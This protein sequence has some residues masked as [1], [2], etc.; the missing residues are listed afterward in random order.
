MDLDGILKEIF[1]DGLLKIPEWCKTENPFYLHSIFYRIGFKDRDKDIE[2]YYAFPGSLSSKIFY[3][4]QGKNEI[5]ETGKKRILSEIKTYYQDFS[6]DYL[7]SLTSN[8]LFFLLEKFGSNI[9]VDDE[10]MISI[11]DRYKIIAARK[12]I[13]T[14]RENLGHSENLFINIDISGIQRFIYN[15]SSA[16][17]L[18]N[19]RSRSF[20][21]ELLCNHIVHKVLNAFNI[22]SVNVIMSGGGTIYILSGCP[23]DYERKINDLCYRL[24]EWLLNEFNGRLYSAITYVRCSDKEL[25]DDLSNILKELSIKAFEDKQRKFKDMIVKGKFSFVEEK[26]PEYLG[27]EICYRDDPPKSRYHRVNEAEDRFRCHLCNRLVNLGNQIPNTRFIYQCDKDSEKCLKIEGSY[28]LLSDQPPGARSID[29]PCLW[30]VYEDRQ[31]FINDLEGGAIHIFA[32]TFTKKNRELK[33][34]IY[35][36][37]VGERKNLEALLSSQEDITYKERLKEEIDMMED[38]HAA[39]FEY[40]AKSAKGAQLIGALRMDA[41]NIGKILQYGFSSETTLE[42]ISS[43]S[44]SLNCFFKLHLE[45]LCKEGFERKDKDSIF[46]VNGDEGRNVHVIY[47]GGDDLFILGAWS[48]IAFLAIDIGESFKKYTCNN[49]DLGISGGLTLHGPRFPINKMADES[50]AALTT[51]KD[52]LQPCWMC[53][54]DWINCRLYKEGECLRKDSLSLFF[55]D[56]LA[57]RKSDLDER[58]KSLKYS[59]EISRL[60]LSLKWKFYETSTKKVINEVEEFAVKPLESFYLGSEKISRVFFHNVLSLLETWYAE[61]LLY[62]PRIVWMIQK[63][64]SDLRRQKIDTEGGKSLYDLYEMFLHFHD[65]GRFSSLH[66]PLSWNILLKK[67]AQDGKK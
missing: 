24:N 43:F 66:I 20:F 16:G 13:K 12:I 8:Q 7:N 22:H 51:A 3:P 61:G 47:A 9:P 23:D 30:V 50:M 38:D 65:P 5:L 56:Y 21:I 2:P 39:T 45:S 48:D 11:F 14:N 58:Y 6:H 42:N 59:E 1:I 49:M 10:C 17:A 26:D 37:I 18:K 57:K 40:I 31:D 54:T 25:E 62:L 35:E 32:R 64:K 53:R 41:D 67:G 55:T 15:I 63:F 4:V 46:A 52:N 44:M 29:Y 28:Y 27:C 36:K 19:L 34:D 60:R 33:K